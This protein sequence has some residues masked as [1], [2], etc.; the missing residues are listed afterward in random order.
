MVHLA[1]L[2]V[3]ISMLPCCKIENTCSRRL[4]RAKKEEAMLVEIVSNL[5]APCTRAFRKNL[6]KRLVNSSRSAA[7][8]ENASTLLRHLT[9]LLLN[10]FRPGILTFFFHPEN[11]ML[12]KYLVY[13][14]NWSNSNKWAVI[15][16]I[17][18]FTEGCSR[19]H[20]RSSSPQTSPSHKETTIPSSPMLSTLPRTIKTIFSTRPPG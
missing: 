12:N 20:V 17:P 14:M 8:S 16:V 5:M 18:L 6:A 1:F 13:V 10:N 3:Q 9:I 2:E 11:N 15:K 7:R 4:T 19:H